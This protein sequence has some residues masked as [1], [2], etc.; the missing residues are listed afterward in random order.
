MK[1]RLAFT[2]LAY[3]LLL[4]GTAQAASP[5]SD[6]A[7]ARDIERQEGQKAAAKLLPQGYAE[8]MKSM[9]SSGGFADELGDLALRNIFGEFWARPGLDPKSRSLAILGSL[10]ALRQMDEFKIHIGIA[11][12]NGCTVT[13][14]QEVILQST[15]YSGFPAAQQARR[16][17]IEAL[18][19]LGLIK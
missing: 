18:T 19:E 17:A 6:L 12:R 11:I 14:I 8:R 13:E 16:A 5:P 4:A 9:A 10:I 1:L 3:S 2:L 15:A 7:A